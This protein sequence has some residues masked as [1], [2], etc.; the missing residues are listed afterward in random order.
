MTIDV[1]E[2]RP[3]IRT[4]HLTGE[5]D[6]YSSN[7][8]KETVAELWKDGHT[9]LVIDLSELDYVD[10]SGI[11]AL[12][13]VYSSSQKRG[14]RIIFCGAT[15]SVLKVIELTKL[16]GFLPLERSL[17]QALEAITPTEEASQ[18]GDS[19]RQLI[20]DPDSPL[21]DTRN[22]YH[23]RFYLDLS[24]VRRLANLIA[25]KAPNH[26]RDINILE[27]QISELLK[28]AVKHGNGN[29]PTKSV[30]VWF[31]FT[32][33]S[34]RLIVEDEGPGFRLLEEWNA[35]YR[36][37]IEAYHAKDFEAMMNYLAFRTDN[38]TEHDGGNAMMAAV[39]YW[40]EGVVFNEPRNRIAVMRSF[41]HDGSES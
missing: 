23:K 8:L 16:D 7:A 37:K 33:E 34:A 30:A 18:Q 3:E 41:H 10:S 25:Q 2:D 39:E 12:L 36:K 6:L 27:Q 29:D 4:I 28:N 11:G 24:K 9:R 21:L 19:I 32:D 35:F 13:G 38:S 40:N 14:H 15:G 22:M 17:E 26:L 5:M 1:S 31:R 20:V